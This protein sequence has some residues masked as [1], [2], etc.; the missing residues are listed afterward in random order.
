MTYGIYGDGYNYNDDDKRT[1]N[2]LLKENQELKQELF[3]NKNKNIDIGFFV[4]E[5]NHNLDQIAE[6]MRYVVKCPVNEIEI[7]TDDIFEYIDM[8]YETINII[9]EKI[10]KEQ[11]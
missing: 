2:D 5:I 11:E 9:K 10:E 8:T 3:E 7:V 4:S 1:Y 6:N